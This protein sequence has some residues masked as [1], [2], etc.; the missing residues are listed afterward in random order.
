MVQ[1]RMC[2]DMKYELKDNISKNPKCTNP[3]VTVPRV[4]D[5]WLAGV[6][7]RAPSWVPVSIL[8]SPH[9]SLARPNAYTLVLYI[10]R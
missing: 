2:V 10:E 9:D 1:N 6:G 8:V 7:K 5:A 3:A 4:G